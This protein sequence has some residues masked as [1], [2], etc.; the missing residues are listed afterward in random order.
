M[1]FPNTLLGQKK[2]QGKCTRKKCAQAKQEKCARDK[3]K[4]RLRRNRRRQDKNMCATEKEQEESCDRIAAT[5]K[6]DLSRWKRQV[7]K[8]KPKGKSQGRL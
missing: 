4:G 8:L 7:E 3:G 5:R 2:G 1:N 6:A